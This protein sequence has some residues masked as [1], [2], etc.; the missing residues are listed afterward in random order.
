MLKKWNG[1]LRF[2]QNFKLRRFT[3]H[4]LTIG[5]TVSR[6][7]SPVMNKRIENS[8][9]TL[10]TNAFEKIENSLHTSSKKNE[11]MPISKIEIME[12]DTNDNGL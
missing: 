2:L 6:P 10:S 11:N 7:A 5:N 8:E 9:K 3:K 12:T 4:F 1:E